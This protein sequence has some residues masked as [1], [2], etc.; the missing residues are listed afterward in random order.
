MSDSKIDYLNPYA[1]LAQQHKDGLDAIITSIGTGGPGTVSLD[2]L[3]DAVYDYLTTVYTQLTSPEGENTTRTTIINAINGYLDNGGSSPYLRTLQSGPVALLSNQ[4]DRMFDASRAAQ[5][6]KGNAGRRQMVI[7]LGQADAEYWGN[8]IDTSGSWIAY[9][10]T[11]SAIDLASLPFWVDAAMFG[12]QFDYYQVN[13]TDSMSTSLVYVSALT[14]S[15]AVAAGK[16]VFG[17][18]PKQKAVSGSTAIKIATAISKDPGILIRPSSSGGVTTPGLTPTNA[19][20]Y[21]YCCDNG[22]QGEL[23]AD[24]ENDAYDILNIAGNLMGTQCS[25]SSNSDAS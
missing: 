21:Q 8:Q 14:G 3:V 24:N 1:T 9:M 13:A 5:H 11:N 17:W 20:V 19:K 16:V 23:V 25:L 10:S 6:L 12:A 7:A 15:L 22:V 18:V 4:F 2:D